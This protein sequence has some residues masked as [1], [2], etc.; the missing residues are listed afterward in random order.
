MIYLDPQVIETI[1]ARREDHV[2][3]LAQLVLKDA[4]D[5]DDDISAQLEAARIDELSSLIAELE[6]KQKAAGVQA[7]G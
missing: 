1:K 2:V 7:N 6:R 4:I 3:V 5:N